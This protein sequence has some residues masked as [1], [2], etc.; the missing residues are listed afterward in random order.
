MKNIVFK[1]KELA[2]TASS[3]GSEEFKKEFN[4][5]YAYVTGGMFRGIASEKIVSAM[6]NAGMMGYFGSG[7]LDISAIEKAIK[8]IRAAIGDKPYGMNFLHNHNNPE[9]EEELS[10][11]Y[12]KYNIKNIEAAAFMNITPALAR[13]RISGLEKIDGRVISSNKIMAKLSRPEVAEAFLSP[14]PEKFVKNLLDTGKITESQAEM[15]KNIPMADA[16][17]AE[18]DS[19][20]HTDRRSP[21]TLIPTIISVRN[22]MMRKYGYE[23]KIFIGAAG[24]IGTPEACAAAFILGADFVLTGSINQCAVEADTS[25]VV[26]DMLSV[27]DVQDTAYAP[28]GDMFEI[29]AKV[30][31]LKK[32]T[33]FHARA[34]KLYNLYVR[35]DSLDEIDEATKNMI[36]KTFFK[37]SFKDVYEDVKKFFLKKDPEQIKLAEKNPKHKMALIFRWYFGYSSKAAIEGIKENKIDFQIHTGSSL[38]AFNRSVKGADLE[39]WRN[40][41]VDKI[42]IKLMEEAAA[43]LNLRFKE[44]TR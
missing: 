29:G 42:G 8:K 2:I 3:L 34:N 4:L 1:D 21:Y 23:K 28:P 40:R 14:A 7:G 6:A 13:Y 33:L 10:D 38:G 26:K 43:L 22:D 35:Y 37:K 36:E 27:M 24:G 9:Q 17:C 5:K 30:Q 12:L 39:D 15:A 19:G 11:I 16:V 32:G 25:D 18:A 41:H 44:M 20:G 31:V